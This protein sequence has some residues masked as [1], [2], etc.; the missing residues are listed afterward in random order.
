MLS[1][2]AP[3]VR[4]PP[5]HNLFAVGRASACTVTVVRSHVKTASAVVTGLVFNVSPIVTF[6]NKVKLL[7]SIA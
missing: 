1:T 7:R 4:K 2:S 5:G 6:D 3:C